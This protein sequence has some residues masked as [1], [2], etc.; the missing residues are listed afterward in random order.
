MST[1]TLQVAALEGLA[2]GRTMAERAQTHAVVDAPT[3]AAAIDMIVVLEAQAKRIKTQRDAILKPIKDAAEEVKAQASGPI[4]MLTA[5]ATA[6]RDRVK[7]WQQAEAQK[8][9]AERARLEAERR[10]V[11]AAQERER[12][13]VEA[14]RKA[15][16]DRHAQEAAEAERLGK[17]APEPMPEPVAVAPAPPPVVTHV[18]EV[19]RTVA[20]NL[21][22]ATVKK[23]WTYEITDANLV[24]RDYCVPSPGLIKRAVDG[25]ARGIAGVRIYEETD[26]AIKR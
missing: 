17:P 4:E 3:S 12:Q 1:T 20:S 13:R 19:P 14:E 15:A 22:T 23:R 26:L 5:A 6:L 10:E 21:G 7:G 16:E 18:P 8:A 25:G 11:E 24:P 2:E 9:E